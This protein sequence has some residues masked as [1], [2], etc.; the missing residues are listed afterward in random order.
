MTTVLAG[1]IGGTHA[2]LAIVEIDGETTRIT[3]EHDFASRDW[4]GLAPVV[5]EFRR[6]AGV[7]VAAACFGLPCPVV[8]GDCHA[9]NLPWAVNAA[10]LAREIDVPH[11][12]IVNDFDAL[13]HGILRLAADDTVVLQPGE[14]VA[15]GTIGYLG[16]GTGLGEGALVWSAGEY[17][18]LASEGGHADFAA[19]TPEE[20]SLADFLRRRHGRV[21]YERILS[22]PGL[23]NVYRWL[24]ATGDTPEQP[25]VRDEIAAGDPAAVIAQ[26]ALAGTDAICTRALEMFVTVYGAEAGNLALSVVATGGIYVA[27]GIAPR[28]LPR[29]R[30]G[31]FL[32]AFRTKGRLSPMLHRIPVHVI[33]NDRVALLGAAAIAARL[34]QG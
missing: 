20:W 16:A 21:S 22:G 34:V 14:P 10:Q 29:I 25:G 5:H 11:T 33:V 6:T 18:V 2:R 9:S 24:V 12:T 1:D 15:R 23:A 4:P 7:A 26:H 31:G 27:G 30:G 19:R 17:R 8:D 13:G 3:Q 32:D 28:V